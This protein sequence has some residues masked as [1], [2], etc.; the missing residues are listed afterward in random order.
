MK[1]KKPVGS[2]VVLTRNNRKEVFLVKR[3]D[4][5]V[6]ECQGGG[7]EDGETPKE[8]AIREAFEETGFKIKI[9]RKIAEYINPE[10]K[11]VDSHVYAGKITSGKYCREYPECEGRWFNINLLPKDMVEVRKMMIQDCVVNKRKLIKRYS[12]SSIYYKNMKLFLSVPFRSIKY[13]AVRL[14]KF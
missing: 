3:S 14:F 4:F 5:P 1:F 13:V 7:I 8:C 11:K 12:P 9:R 2:F 10:T 6:W